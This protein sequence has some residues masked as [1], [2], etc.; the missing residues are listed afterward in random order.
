MPARFQRLTRL[1]IRH[2]KP[3]ERITE[4]GITA[5]ALV[6][7]DV[8][9]TVN[10]MAD[11][12]RIHR[13]VGL[14]S[15]R[16]TREQCEAFIAQARTDARHGRLNL[17]KRRKTVL[18]FEQ[19]AS[20][21]LERLA[22]AGD[23]DSH[24]RGLRLR[25]HL[26][27]AFGD[28]PLAALTDL[29]VERYKRARR[30]AGAKPATVNRELSVLSHLL[31]KA[32]EWKWIDHK[33]CRLRREKEGAGRLVYL[34]V[35]QARRLLDAAQDSGNPYLYPFVLIGLETAMRRSEIC[36][37]RLADIDLARRIIRVPRAKAGPRDQPI[38]RHLAEYLDAYLSLACAPGQE[39]LFPAQRS[40][41]G[42][43]ENMEKPFRRAVIE[44]G[45]DV[46][47]VTR[48]TLRHTAI[49]H[50]VQEGVD[51][52]TVQRIS[53]HKSLQMVVRY[54]HQNAEHIQAAMD[55]LE[56]RYRGTIT[57]ELHREKPKGSAN[58]S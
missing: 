37:I 14:A 40:R 20:Q 28:K 8:R 1:A 11:G 38:T 15:D 50:L 56:S 31:N 33:P 5:E 19:A 52:P 35:E 49:S 6:G 32:V 43:M 23:A 22:A 41:S 36:R 47:E 10:I 27:P 29:D 45:L 25:L 54:S 46:K 55:R 34:T 44:A 3:G 18:R 39:W 21:Y 51:L 30:D 26:I 7:G 17:P 16:V 58:R 42:H 13:V 57:Q 4:G 9:Y 48:H 53:G 12:A 2:L 24:K